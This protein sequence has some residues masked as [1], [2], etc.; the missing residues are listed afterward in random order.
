MKKENKSNKSLFYYKHKKEICTF[1][2]SIKNGHNII[3]N[4]KKK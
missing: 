4:K 1:A 2:A 3:I